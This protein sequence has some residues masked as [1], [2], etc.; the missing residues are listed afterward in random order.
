VRTLNLP[1]E[2]EEVDATPDAQAKAGAG[3]SSGEGGGFAGASEPIARALPVEPV[4]R[5]V[6]VSRDG[7]AGGDI[8]DM[9][10]SRE[11]AGESVLSPINASETEWNIPDLNL[12]FRPPKFL[13]EAMSIGITPEKWVK[14]APNAAV[15]TTRSKW[16][17]LKTV[18]S[19]GL[20][21]KQSGE[22]A[23]LYSEEERDA[24][25][26]Q[27]QLEVEQLKN[28][29]LSITKA[30]EDLLLETDDGYGGMRSRTSSPKPLG[31]RRVSAA[32]TPLEVA[33]AISVSENK[34]DRTPQR[35]PIAVKGIA[36]GICQLL[37]QGLPGQSKITAGG[38]LDI[39]T[40][41]SGIICPYP[42]EIAE[43]QIIEVCGRV[44]KEPTEKE[45][46]S[47]KD[48]GGAAAKTNNVNRSVLFPSPSPA[49]PVRAPLT[50]LALSNTCTC[51]LV[52]IFVCMHV[53][54]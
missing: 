24:R 45:K 41:A 46:A 37:C 3:D 19:T 50:T 6:P 2:Q 17:T 28:F 18:M 39:D 36:T 22:A 14:L 52:N 12:I 34:K 27:L 53:C 26:K 4:A 38:L 21:F 49:P 47:A 42:S 1:L 35:S 5:A 44:P 20:A 23:D 13:M 25:K 31:T 51:T 16:R 40:L 15:G 30:W 10:N 7:N 9:L 43:C 29:L 11:N 54:V 48:K 8:D 32:D 33:E